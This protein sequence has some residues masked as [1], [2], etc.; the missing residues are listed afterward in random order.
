MSQGPIWGQHFLSDSRVTRRIA[1][2]I[3]F[4]QKKFVNYKNL[5]LINSDILSL[6]L[7]KLIKDRV[8][9]PVIVTGNLPYYITSPIMRMIFAA[10]NTLSYALLLMQKEVAER[11][12]AQPNT[13]NYAFL[14]VLSSLYS[15]P[16]RLFNVPARAFRP[17]PKIESSV[18]QFTIHQKNKPESRF[19]EFLKLCFSQPR[20]IL[21]N[22]LSNIY[23]R[24]MLENMKITRC[25][26]QQLSVQD[27]HS[28]WKRITDH[29]E[30]FL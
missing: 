19:I 10:G 12:V 28:L 9:G 14:S 8:E 2:L 13:K 27:L 17:P 22:N 11:V 21:L 7:A 5:E 18:V 29:K 4:L 20:K 24:E 25:R 15:Q 3:G 16:K 1:V 23:D 30:P 26:A 6:N